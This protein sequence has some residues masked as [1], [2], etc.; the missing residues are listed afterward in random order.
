MLAIDTSVLIRYLVRDDPG[1][2]GRARALVDGSDIVVSSTVMLEAEWVLRSA[3]GFE[4]EACARSLAAFA[5]LPRVTV[6]DPAAVA[7]ALD[8]ARQGVDFADALHLA[9]AQG[10]EAFASF[11]RDLARKAK[12]LDLK[13][14]TP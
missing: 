2:A 4:A 10:C 12:K 5:G 11:D 9:K 13:I 3:Y 7:K 1:Q 8:W 6:D 14:R